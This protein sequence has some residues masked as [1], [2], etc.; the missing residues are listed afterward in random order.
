[1]GGLGRRRFY[2]KQTMNGVERGNLL[3][4]VIH[5]DIIGGL[6]HLAH[7]PP[8]STLPAP[9]SDLG[10]WGVGGGSSGPRQTLWTL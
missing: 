5:N 8:S 3:G 9:A 1:M 10:E 7:R 2:S 6:V 4:T